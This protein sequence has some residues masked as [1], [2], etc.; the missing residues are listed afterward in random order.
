MT[1]SRNT[2]PP[3]WMANTDRKG[4]PIPQVLLGAAEQVW[5]RVLY[6]AER[7]LK[8]T[9]VAAEILE[10]AVGVATR[11]MDRRGPEDRILNPAS[12]LYWT[13]ARILCRRLRKQKMIQLI[14]D[15]ERAAAPKRG[16]RWNHIARVEKATLVS[17]IMKYMDTR[18][19][20]I[21]LLRVKSYSWGEIGEKLGIT[22]NNAAVQFSHG[23]NKARQRIAKRTIGRGK[24][25]ANGAR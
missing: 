24:S 23:V 1:N 22:G 7:E 8:D 11:R 2:D 4:R 25:A 14:E 6:L 19:R 12:Y 5:P 3:F 16:F 18:T 17:E 15:L 20:R 13:A 10:A 9:A 21:F